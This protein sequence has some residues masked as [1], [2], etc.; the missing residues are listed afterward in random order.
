MPA[1]EV[2]WTWVLESPLHAGAGLSRPGVA[3]RLIQRDA[4]NGPTVRGDA[5]K[6]ALRMAAEQVADWL[7]AP[8][9]YESNAEPRSWPLARLF[10]GDARARFGVNWLASTDTTAV[11]AST[12]IERDTGRAKDQTLRKIEVLAPG[13]K[14]NA[15]VAVTLEKTDDPLLL[16]TLL[17]AAVGAAENLG[18][19]AGIG[20]GR[21]RVEDLTLKSPLGDTTDDA[22]RANRLKALGEALRTPYVPRKVAW[23]TPRASEPGEWYRLDLTL[24]DPVCFADLPAVANAIETDEVISATTLRGA[25]ARAWR[26]AA[27]DEEEILAW[28]GEGTRWSP[29]FPLLSGIRYVPTP[30]SFQVP[31]RRHAPL[32]DQLV[33][34]APLFDDEGERFQLRGLTTKWVGVSDR[35]VRAFDAARRKEVRMHVAREYATGGAM[36]GALFA[37]ESLLPEDLTFVAYACLPPAAIA[38]LG[39]NATLSLGKRRSAG[40]GRV[41]INSARLQPADLLHGDGE[42]NSVFVQLLSPAIVRDSRTGYFLRTISAVQ[43]LA[44]VE[45]A[46][47]VALESADCMAFTAPGRRGGWMSNWSHQRAAVATVDAGSVWCLT[48]ADNESADR[49]RRAL[50]AQ[51][52]I[53]ERRHEGFGWIVV[54][55]KW[56][57]RFDANSDSPSGVDQSPARSTRGE[58]QPW[59]GMGASRH[60]ALEVA[61]ELP[62]SVDAM[63]KG[64]L[65][66]LAT[67][68]RTATDA[69][70]LEGLRTHCDR[71]SKRESERNPWRLLRPDT[72]GKER[73]LLDRYWYG[74]DAKHA[75]SPALLRFAI[76]ALLIRTSES[77]PRG[78][79]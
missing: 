23:K 49:L 68:A 41:S 18:G 32:H 35:E 60:R 56:L 36:R 29:G 31:K 28:L 19:K 65:Q 1:L 40:N 78:A 52:Q 62:R 66:Q 33:G 14:I 50:H 47:D 16:A 51:R 25:L 64:P 58:Q 57:G 15:T 9:Q 37:R 45:A 39:K 7:G 69:T 11:L 3:D 17:V 70:G 55:P 73:I 8:Q 46:G 10:G 63:L 21:L 38:A 76:E 74:E 30:R 6:G 12:S 26:E 2:T 48:C 44:Q 43:W 5:V 72:P 53:G 67:M 27:V 24:L 22:V 77:E 71:M 75:E 79:S 13:S 34:D 54:D 20:W 59:P 42:G 4:N 61:H